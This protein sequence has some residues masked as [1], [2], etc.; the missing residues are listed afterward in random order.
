MPVP[1]KEIQI[2]RG[3]GPAYLCGKK[4]AKVVTTMAE[5]SKVFAE[6][7]LTAP[8]TGGYD[9]CDFRITFE[10]GEVYEGRADIKRAN[11]TGYDLTDHVVSFLKYL[12]GTNKPTHLNDHLWACTCA[13][14]E[15]DGSASAARAY[16]AKYFTA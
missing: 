6:I 10:D 15:S 3:E 9:K 7:A 2:I 8:S 14:N 16:L 11:V 5:A 1:I 13:R 4:N 12:S